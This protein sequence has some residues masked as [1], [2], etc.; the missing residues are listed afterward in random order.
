MERSV[1]QSEAT[2]MGTMLGRAYAQPVGQSLPPDFLA[3]L[4]ALNRA[5]EE[6]PA[7]ARS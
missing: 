6:A 1:E 7:T 3:M 2:M 5:K 4:V